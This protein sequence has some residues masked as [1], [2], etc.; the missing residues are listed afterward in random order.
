MAQELEESG[1]FR[2]LKRV[3]KRTPTDRPISSDERMVVFIDTETT[4]LEPMRDEVI[5]LGM[6]AVAY[7]LGGNI[8][9]SSRPSVPSESLRYQ[10]Q[11]PPL[12]A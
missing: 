5:E 8:P 4:G 9:T 10:S 12:R 11:R 2:V 7:D 6:M 1:L 3:P